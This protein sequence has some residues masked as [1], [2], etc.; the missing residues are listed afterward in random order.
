MVV[1]ALNRGGYSLKKQAD[2]GTRPGGGKHLVDVVATSQSGKS[3]LISVK[4][5]Q[6]GGT[7]EQKVP[8]EVTC[9]IKALKNNESKYEKAY[10]VL[11]GDGWKLRDYYIEG[12]L[13]EYLKDSD[14]VKIITLESFIALANKGNL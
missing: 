10:L 12:G 4:W 13:E 8:F 7:A 9:L 2:V 6:V 14:L 11:G 1:P 3:I 5:Q